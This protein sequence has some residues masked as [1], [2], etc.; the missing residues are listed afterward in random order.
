MVNGLLIF[1]LLVLHNVIL[2]NGFGAL[3]MQRNKTN[4]SYKKLLRRYNH[5]LPE[6]GQA[7]RSHFLLS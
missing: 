2:T 1:S 3:G 4:F 6:Y 5:A 7:R